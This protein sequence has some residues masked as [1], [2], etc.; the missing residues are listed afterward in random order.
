MARHEALPASLPP[1]GLCRI[2]AAQYVGVSPVTFDKMVADGRMP[3]PK[4]VDGRKLWDLRKLDL[5]FEALPDEEAP[6]PWDAIA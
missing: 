2:M 3:Q 5:A 1:R 4:R 6:N